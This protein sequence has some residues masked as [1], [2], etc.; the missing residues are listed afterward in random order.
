MKLTIII[1]ICLF[2]NII[3]V[4]QKSLKADSLSNLTE[5]SDVSLVKFDNKGEYLAVAYDFGKLEIWDLHNNSNML[6][7]KQFGNSIISVAFIDDLNQII[8]VLK[9]VGII[10]I[11]KLTGEISKSFVIDFG[12][13]VEDE[14]EKISEVDYNP[15]SKILAVSG[16]I[17]DRVILLNLETLYNSKVNNRDS[18]YIVKTTDLHRSFPNPKESSQVITVFT[19]FKPDGSVLFDLLSNIENYNNDAEIITCIK[20]SPNLKFVIAGTKSGKLLKWNLTESKNSL[21]PEYIIPVVSSR[22]QT[23]YKD[24]LGIDC[25]DSL[26]VSV[27]FGSDLCGTMQL[28]DPSDMSIINFKK[29]ADPSTCRRIKLSPK[30]DYSITTGDFSYRLW[31]REEM[32]YIL[33]LDFEYLKSVGYN[34]KSGSVDFSN[35]TLA[36][37]DSD[38]VYFYQLPD[39]NYLYSLRKSINGL[40]E[41]HHN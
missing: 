10:Y 40:K 27:S 11:D 38:D 21:F 25:N 23:E 32:N 34:K 36:I 4:A 17:A 8:V 1:L 5:S 28:W 15:I 13:D 35:K 16:D 33:Q 39:F 41:L 37:G 31:K 30:Y 7:H 22:Q 3:A 14:H 24:I 19:D 18:I 26:L 29:Q 9:S 20:M 6:W 12:E 2:L